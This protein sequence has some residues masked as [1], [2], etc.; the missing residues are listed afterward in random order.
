MTLSGRVVLVTGASGGL[1][2][3][4]V[5]AFRAA[6]A[7][8]LT[9]ARSAG[10]IRADLAAPEGAR[11]A[12]AEAAAKAGP[13]AVL[14]HLM[15]GFAGG[16]PV[17][18]TDDATWRGMMATNLD[19]AFYMARA[20]LPAMIAAGRGRILMVGARAALEPAPGA[21]AYAVAKAGLV[22]LVRT[23]AAEVKESG[24]TV[25]AVLPS[26]IDTPGNRAA[27]PKARHDRWVAPESIARLLLWLASDEAAE[28]SGAAIP[29]YGRA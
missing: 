11:T 22:Q 24:V 13:I 7:T 6:G 25:N 4:V 23:L 27:M 18:E 12:L 10:D 1:G 20:V 17:A 16:R 28:V 21:A 9:A 29:I 5:P 15:G 2:R 3:A 19:A 14:A 26:I 8:V